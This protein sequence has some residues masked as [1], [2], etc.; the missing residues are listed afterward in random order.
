MSE[1]RNKQYTS[2]A[3]ITQMA[4]LEPI[5]PTKGQDVVGYYNLTYGSVSHSEATKRLTQ[6]LA[7]H[8]VP[9]ILLARL[10]VDIQYQ[11]KILGKGLQK[12]A[13]RN[14]SR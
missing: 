8:E 6:G 9:V 5:S 4:Q 10:A 14:S 13:A 7:K 3:K 1:K 12:D 11:N 2:E